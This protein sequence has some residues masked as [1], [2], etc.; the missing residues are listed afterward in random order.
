[1]RWFQQY[2]VDAFTSVEYGGN[3]AAVCLLEGDISA[4]GMQTI[5]AENN[6]SE[7]AFVQ[8]LVESTQASQWETESIFSLRWFTPLREVG[9]GSG[10]SVDWHIICCDCECE[11][12]A[13]THAIIGLSGPAL[14]SRDSSSRSCPLQRHQE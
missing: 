4:Q 7:T 6:L 12:V 13:Y 8:P 2:Q 5:A 11:C 10:S 14:R 1:M 3:P 9:Q